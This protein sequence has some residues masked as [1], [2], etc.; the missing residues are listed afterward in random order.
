MHIRGGG[1]RMTRQGGLVRGL[2]A[3]AAAGVSVWCGTAGAQVN[4]LNEEVTRLVA[5]RKLGEARV[6]ISLVD[7]ETGATLANVHGGDPFT[8]ASNMKL[9]TSGAALLV[10]TPDFA[11]RTELIRDGDRL[12][13]R[14]AGDPA[15]ADP[16][17]LQSM[18]PRLTVNDVLGAL[19]GA[20]A[21]A[22]MKDVR[23]VVVDDR[24]FD[25]EYVH[26]EW[27]VKQLDRGY[28][29]EVS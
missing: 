20:V 27:P 12:I 16:V 8:P 14:G 3:V 5:A 26:P 17:V 29:A 2:V 21:K 19:A 18:E 28:C 10:L 25:R 24:V 15:L 13:L 1:M 22:E 9:L 23:E 4:S 7:L 11:F 6:G